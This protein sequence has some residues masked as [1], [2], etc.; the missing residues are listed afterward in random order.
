MADKGGPGGFTSPSFLLESVVG[1]D[2]LG[3]YSYIGVAPKEGIILKDG[4]I[5]HLRRDDTVSS[6]NTESTDPLTVIQDQVS[7]VIVKRSDLPPFF[8]GYVGYLGYEVINLFEPK[9]PVSNPDVLGVPDAM[10]FNYDNVVVFDHAKN[11]V[12]V[13][14]NIDVDDDLEEGYQQT[15]ARIDQLVDRIQ[16]TLP[17]TG[18]K[19]KGPVE[20]QSTRSNFERPEYLK[21]VERIKEY[22]IAGDT[23]QVVFSQRFARK[24]DADPFSLYRALRR[25]NPSP[26]M[27]YF[28]YGDFQIIG[29]SPELLLKVEEGVITT[30][31]IAGTRPRGKT[32]EEDE[33]LAMELSHNEKEKAEHRMLL[34]LGRNDVGRVSAPGTVRVP[35]VMEIER[36]SHVMHL[37]SEVQGRLSDQYTSLDALRSVFPAGTLSGAP[38][39]RAMQIIDELE[40]EKRG[41]YGG[42]MGYISYNG[43]LE[44]AITIRTMVFKDGTAYI[45]AGGGIVYDSEPEAEFMETISKAQASMR[46]ID[47]AEEEYI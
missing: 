26:F 2:K 11:E 23:I 21:R 42:A 25:V 34:D 22:I 43:N 36:F 33:K 19:S 29:A 3:R 27:A 32:P 40:Q 5:S 45:Q 6:L 4:K 9:V 20:H 35:K 37:S 10:L 46:A 44:M 47:L 13:I 7:R 8:G 1:G 41:P 39:I 15:T 12:K 38:K 14:G 31:P 17:L 24:T 28:D 18:K 16:T 30:C